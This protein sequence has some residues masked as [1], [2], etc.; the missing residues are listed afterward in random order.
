[1]GKAKTKDRLR[2]C[3]ENS[4]CK[5]YAKLFQ[6]NMPMQAVRAVQHNTAEAVLRKS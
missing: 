6:Q 1:M 5:T 3:E 2:N 4:V